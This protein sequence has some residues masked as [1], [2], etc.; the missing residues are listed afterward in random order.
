M[1]NE[2]AKIEWR[3]TPTPTRGPQAWEQFILHVR[4]NPGAVIYEAGNALHDHLLT[5]GKLRLS[6]AAMAMRTSQNRGGRGARST[7]HRLAHAIDRAKANAAT[8]EARI[9]A[10]FDAA[11]AERPER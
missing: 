9:G 3:H 6:I 10:A 1:A 5:V 7:W 2:R 8:A 11:I 4:D